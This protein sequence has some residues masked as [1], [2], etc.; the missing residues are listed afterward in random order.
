MKTVYSGHYLR[1]DNFTYQLPR[2]FLLFLLILKP[3]NFNLYFS[4]GE[5]TSAIKCVQAAIKEHEDDIEEP[6]A[7]ASDIVK[8]RESIVGKINTIISQIYR[9]KVAGQAGLYIDNI[10][11]DNGYIS[12]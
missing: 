4:L 10:L 1:Q 7:A 9:T 3:C 6:S 8:I 12:D 5:L 2:L 11:A